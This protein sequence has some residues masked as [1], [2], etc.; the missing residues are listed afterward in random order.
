MALSMIEYEVEITTPVYPTERSNRVIACLSRVFPEAE[1]EDGEEKVE[2]HTTSLETFKE[3]LED[4]KIRDTA[5][6]YML[7]RVQ[8]NRCT[9]TISKQACC[10][11]KV[12]FS[13]PEDQPLGG[14]EVSI[15]TEGNEDQIKK[16][17][18]HLT[19]IEE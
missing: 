5:R 9:F 3:I 4:M 11:S 8:G 19:E 2:G 15:K 1:W 13:S 12:N 18:H 17:V 7:K 10:S 16:V 14:V 6:S